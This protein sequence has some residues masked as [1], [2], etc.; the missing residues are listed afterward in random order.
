MHKIDSDGATITN[1]FTEGN[2]SLSIPA[3]V[4]SAAIM[5]AIQEE[6]VTVIEGMGLTLLTSGTDTWDQLD[7]ALRKMHLLGGREAAI[8]DSLPNNQA[9]P[10]L[11]NIGSF[12]STITKGLEFYYR[13]LRRTD[14]SYM[15]ESGRL[16][17]TYDSEASNWKVTKASVHDDS[18]VDFSMVLNAG[19]TW[20]M[21]YTTS[22]LAGASYSGQILITDL[23]EIRP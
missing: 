19:T 21:K 16:Y 1:L 12:D 9:A 10:A 15:V 17:A 2:P 23:K 11:L 7:A 18:E 8:T 4:V 3:T 13:I 5:N 6:L 14:S 20:E 22:N